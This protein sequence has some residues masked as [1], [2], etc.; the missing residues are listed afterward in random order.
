[1]GMRVIP[2]IAASI[3]LTA[4]CGGVDEPLLRDHYV[5]KSI[6]QPEKTSRGVKRD[7]YGNPVLTPARAWWWPFGD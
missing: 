7:G 2:V 6:L 4:A 5:G 1:M 3:L